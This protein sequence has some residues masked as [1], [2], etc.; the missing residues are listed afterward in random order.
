MYRVIT[1]TLVIQHKGRVRVI[2]LGPWQPTENIA[3]KWAQYLE[4]TGLYDSVTIQSNGQDK[5]EA[6][7]QEAL[8]F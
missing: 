1:K 2:D 5:V 4:T 8:S 3:Q 6:V 7:A